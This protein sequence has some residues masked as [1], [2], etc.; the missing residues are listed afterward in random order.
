MPGAEARSNS[1][2]SPRLPPQT[3]LQ[4]GLS[5]PGSPGEFQACLWKL[6]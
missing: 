6:S 1:V 2:Q 4:F 3:N 5:L